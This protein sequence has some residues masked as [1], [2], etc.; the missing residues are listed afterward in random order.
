MSQWHSQSSLAGSVHTMQIIVAAITAGP[1]IFLA[2]MKEGQ[3][4][5]LVVA[6]LLSA[7]LVLH[8]PTRAGVEDW[9]DQKLRQIE[10]ERPSR[11]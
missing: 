11:P 8:M 1:A 10:L 7:A 2:Y 4:I 5:S 9:I 6:G 3:T